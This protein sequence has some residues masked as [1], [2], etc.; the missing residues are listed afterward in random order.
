MTTLTTRSIV[1][2]SIVYPKSNFLALLVIYVALLCQQFIFVLINQSFLENR[3]EIWEILDLRRDVAENCPLLSYYA[4]SCGSDH[5]SRRNNPRT[6]FSD[7]K[8]V[9]PPVPVIF[10]AYKHVNLD[11]KIGP[12]RHASL[13]CCNDV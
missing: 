2:S 11:Y 4:A 12:L 8:F 9:I 5:H 1:C 3:Y 13:S 7:M 10:Y 6:R